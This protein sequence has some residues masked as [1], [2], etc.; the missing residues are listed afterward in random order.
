MERFP[1]LN[2]NILELIAGLPNPSSG[3]NVRAMPR[4]PGDLSPTKGG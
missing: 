3:E 1:F 4:T 2:L